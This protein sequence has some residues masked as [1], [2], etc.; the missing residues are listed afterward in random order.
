MSLP[1]QV[2]DNWQLNNLSLGQYYSVKDTNGILFGTEQGPIKWTLSAN[3][4]YFQPT[5]DENQ[6]I[7]DEE[8]Q[9]GATY[10]FLTR[11]EYKL[12]GNWQELRDYNSPSGNEKGLLLG[13]GAGST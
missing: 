1:F 7:V 6:N 9:D 2:Q 11:L 3:N 5:E 13:L 4:G 12:L 10:A 8:F